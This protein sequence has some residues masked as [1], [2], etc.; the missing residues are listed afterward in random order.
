[1]NTARTI[2]A[3]ALVLLS[4][5][6]NFHAP[7]AR[8]EL[9]PDQSYWMS[10]DASRRGAIIVAEGTHVK[11]C[12]E[13]TPDVA[14]S[15]VNTLK[16][17]YTLPGNTSATGVDASFNATA[18]ALAGRDNV[19]LLAREALFR[20]CEGSINGTIAQADVRP[21]FENVFQQVTRIAEAQAHKAES[22]A[23]TARSQV[24]QL[25]LMNEK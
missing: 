1:M 6:A 20:I 24:Q 3:L 23:Q 13:P 15:F 16:G 18:M 8:K 21:L 11:T 17:D 14:M 4:G 12:A 22:D 10:Y 2:A 19:V 9:K 7:S 25:Q 5:C